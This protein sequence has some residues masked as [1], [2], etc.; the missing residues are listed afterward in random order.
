MEE[1]RC[2]SMKCIPVGLEFAKLYKTEI[3]PIY[4][5]HEEKFDQYGIHGKMQYAGH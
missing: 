3:F 5:S 1:H 4:T 2:V